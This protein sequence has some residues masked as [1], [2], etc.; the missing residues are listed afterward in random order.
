MLKG[1]IT[2]KSR[3]Y[4]YVTQKRKYDAFRVSFLKASF[5]SHLKFLIKLCKLLAKT[6]LSYLSKIK[7]ETQLVYN[8]L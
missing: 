4:L 3:K 6:R 2:P 7:A 8:E 1:K 5:H